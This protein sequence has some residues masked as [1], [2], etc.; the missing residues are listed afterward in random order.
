MC[1]HLVNSNVMGESTGF[2][3]SWWE[4]E[5]QWS[6]CGQCLGSGASH[7][8]C[9]GPISFAGSDCF[10]S[11]HSVLSVT[12]NLGLLVS[13]AGVQALAPCFL[14]TQ[15][16]LE[17]MLYKLPSCHFQEESNE[18][19]K[20]FLLSASDCGLVLS[21]W[22]SPARNTHMG[23]VLYLEKLSFKAFTSFI[24]LN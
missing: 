12:A 10:S 4:V 1:Y 7:L 5:P 18:L 2:T 6:C 19:F 9:G 13:L 15:V 22:V 24:T 8:L 21:E 14:F 17:R 20:C 3:F 16:S 23:G 11:V